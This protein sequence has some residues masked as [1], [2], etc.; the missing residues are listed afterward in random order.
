MRGRHSRLERAIQGEQPDSGADRGSLVR[1]VGLQRGAHSGA[2]A[3]QQ[4]ALIPFTQLQRM[5]DLVTRPAVDIA[6]G[7]NLALSGR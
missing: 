3:M 6:Q 1:Q 5:A 2:A 7:D 4:H